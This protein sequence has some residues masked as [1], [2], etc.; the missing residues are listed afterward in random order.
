MREES[1]TDQTYILH[2]AAE[3]VAAAELIDPFLAAYELESLPESSESHE[4]PILAWAIYSFDY[5]P[6]DAAD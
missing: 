5:Q 4:S 6:S 2:V 3:G 1:E